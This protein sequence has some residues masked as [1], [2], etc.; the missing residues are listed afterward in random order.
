MAQMK[1]EPGGQGS[2]TRRPVIPPPATPLERVRASN[3]KSLCFR[4]F[5]CFRYGLAQDMFFV[6]N[7]RIS[8]TMNVLNL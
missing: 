8:A 5:W 7:Q 4:N 1:P 3:C 6:E 2:S